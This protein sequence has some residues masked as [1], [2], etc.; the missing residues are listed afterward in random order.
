MQTPRGEPLMKHA[1][2][3]ALLLIAFAP[4]TNAQILEPDP[5]DFEWVLYPFGTASVQGR[6]STWESVQWLRNVGDIPLR[7]S[8]LRVPTLGP[9]QHEFLLQ[10]DDTFFPQLAGSAA[11]YEGAY[12]FIERGAADKLAFSL[13]VFETSRTAGNPQN[14]P[15]IEIPVFTEAD[16]ESRLTFLSVYPTPR[17]RVTLR[18]FDPEI[19][20]GATVRIVVREQR[21]QGSIGDDIL[22][23]DQTL[24]LLEGFV[25]RARPD[26][27][28]PEIP[29]QLR[30]NLDFSNVPTGKPYVVD[31]YSMTEG[32]GICG[33]ITI[34]DNVTQEVQIVTS[35]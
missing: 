15:G 24:P 31:V 17:H 28:V 12:T 10:P 8:N 1:T 5:G 16:L 4:L 20:P 22:V 32:V 6:S 23:S 13:R 2:V 35:D 18:V 34:T 25:R 29:S 9:G 27:L 7:V 14:H 3:L 30:L 26:G 19:T 11:R 21:H 33:F